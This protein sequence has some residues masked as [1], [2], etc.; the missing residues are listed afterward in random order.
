MHR[1]VVL[2]ALYQQLSHKDADKA[3]QQ[4]TG[5]VYYQFWF[6]IRS[7]L[8]NR[9]FVAAVCGATQDSNCDKDGAKKVDIEMIVL[10]KRC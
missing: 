9:I 5:F 10:A 1:A 6:F 2:R 7:F 8:L 4:R 3:G